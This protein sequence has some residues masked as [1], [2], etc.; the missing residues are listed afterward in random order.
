MKNFELQHSEKK[1]Y[2]MQYID[3][4][5]SLYSWGDIGRMEIGWY[6]L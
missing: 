3:T 6:V 5:H 4:R 2:E 1:N